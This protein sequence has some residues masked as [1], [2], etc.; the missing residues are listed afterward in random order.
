MYRFQNHHQVRA[1]WP[2]EMLSPAS[3]SSRAPTGTIVADPL[4]VGLGDKVVVEPRPS[5]DANRRGY[6]V[7]SDASSERTPNCSSRLS[8]TPAQAEEATEREASS[9][10]G[11]RRRRRFGPDG[12]DGCECDI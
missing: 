2:I 4:V 10:Q 11:D 5:R 6:S 9:K 3:K 1:V 7:K 8:S 12:D